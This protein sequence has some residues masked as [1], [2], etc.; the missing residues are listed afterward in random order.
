MKPDFQRTKQ[1]HFV[2]L[3]LL[4]LRPG[5]G[6]DLRQRINGSVRHFWRES[7]GQIYPALKTM[8][9]E[10]LVKSR[11]EAGEGRPDRRVYEITPKGSKVL[12]LWL[13]ESPKLEV[14]RNE[15]LLKLFFGKRVTL[16]QNRRLIEERRQVYEETNAAYDSIEKQLLAKS[17][18][19]PNLP[20]WLMTL[21][22]GQQHARAE[23]AWCE[24]TIGMLRS[25]QKKD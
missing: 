4:H 20:F 6:Y 2:L 23:V 17:A 13:H 7:W 15:M 16:E 18:D 9:S 19:D 22:H 24:E 14:P 25:M 1:S 8:E 5:S 11:V 10:K 21:R 3:G 12:E